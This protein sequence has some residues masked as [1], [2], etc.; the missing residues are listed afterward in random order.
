MNKKRLYYTILAA[1]IIIGIGVFYVHTQRQKNFAKTREVFAPIYAYSGKLTPEQQKEYSDL[2][3]S[4]M[5]VSPDVAQKYR[6]PQREQWQLEA[7][8]MTLYRDN[9]ELLLMGQKSFPADTD[10]QPYQRHFGILALI[11]KTKLADLP[12]DSRKMMVM[13]LESL[14]KKLVK[15]SVET[16]IE[17]ITDIPPGPDPKLPYHAFGIQSAGINGADQWVMEEDG[18]LH[19]PEGGKHGVVHITDI[20]G[21]EY[22]VDLDSLA[23]TGMTENTTELY[24]KIDRLFEK[25]TDEEF[26]RLSKFSKTER[27]EAIETLFSS[28]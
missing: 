24:A 27:T 15:N 26:Q 23:D 6:L 10:V 14:N 12:T 17:K 22:S 18:S 2:A 1:V 13:Q 20:H 7:H 16:Y 11:A 21:K 19:F 9:P 3:N 25:L 8:T 4:L 5:N 28:L